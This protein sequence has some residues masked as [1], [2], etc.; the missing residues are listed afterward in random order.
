MKMNEGK[1]DFYGNRQETRLFYFVYDRI[2]SDLIE[3]SFFSG[4]QPFWYLVPLP[5]AIPP[6]LRS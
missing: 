5:E 4:S 1:F 3:R 6:F 2:M